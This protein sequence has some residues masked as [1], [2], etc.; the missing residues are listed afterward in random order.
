[1][2]VEITTFLYNL[3]RQSVWMSDTFLAFVNNFL[4]NNIILERGLKVLTAS[5]R[6]L[7]TMP[8]QSMRP[9]MPRHLAGRA[10]SPRS[11]RINW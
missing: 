7:P 6:G 5:W 11:K 2:Q 10:F 4:L 3:G 1:M 8:C 9:T